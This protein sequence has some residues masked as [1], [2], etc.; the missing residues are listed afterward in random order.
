VNDAYCNLVGYTREELLNMSVRD[1]EAI[2]TAEDTIQH[3]QRMV[4]LGSDRFET[5]HRC[6]DGMIVDIEVSANYMDTKGGRFF[7]FLRD[8]TGRKKLDEL[9]DEFIGLV[10]HEMR[11]PLTVI[12][13]ALHTIL[14]EETRL[15][16]D[17]RG[18][19][20]QDAVWEAES[21]SHLLSNLLELSRAQSER[22]LLHRESISIE[23]LVQDVADRINQQSL[24]HKF[25]IDVRSKLPRIY[26]DPVRLEHILR[27][28]LENAV[29]YSPKNSQ[30]T[31]SIK[32]EKENLVVAVKDQG[33]G[34]SLHD[35]DKLFKPFER[36]GF[37]QD[38][39]VKGIGLGLLVCKRL[40]EAHGG[41][42]WV[43]S[44]PGRGATFLFTLP[45]ERHQVKRRSSTV[46]D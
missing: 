8:I 29:K 35:Q 38:S 17:E 5:R 11:T 31:V 46:R 15:S 3:I 23:A 19:L 32:P 4:E 7:V 28:L 39:T 27:N 43:E 6:K 16:A 10:S 9:K 36:L 45:L 24:S 41:R 1:V 40:V 30:I 42:M 12:I 2:E 22:L 44:E 34:I 37:S 26:A 14:T 20:L 25:I 18:Q 21:L 13:G 33:V